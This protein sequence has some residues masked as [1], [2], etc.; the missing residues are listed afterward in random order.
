MASTGASTAATR[1]DY[2]GAPVPAA[3][4][5]RDNAMRTLD[6]SV[7]DG[8][9]QARGAETVERLIE[10][11]TPQSR[12]WTARWAAATGDPNYLRAVA[13]KLSPTPTAASCFVD[14]AESAAWRSAA[15]VQAER[16]MSTTD[17]SGGF[18]IPMQLDP[19]SCCR[20][21]VLQTRCGRWRAWCK[22]PATPGTASPAPASARTGTPKRPKS[23][24]IRRHWC[25]RPS[26][27]TAAAHGSHSASNLKVTAQDFVAEIGRLLADSVEQLTATAY[28]TGS[29]SGQPTGFITAL[30][31]SNP[32]VIVT[33]DGS[34]ALAAT[35]PY[36]LQNA[37]PARF[38]ANSAFAANLS[39]KILANSRQN[40]ALKFPSLQDN[41]PRLLGRRHVRGSEYG[42]RAKH[43]RHRSQLS[44]GA[45]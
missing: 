42:F 44:A 41:P 14:T 6:R 27:Y 26:R 16:A 34:E 4:Q 10:V 35:D 28:V 29:G 32:T 23:P 3:V 18:L 11:G 43:L 21:P 2:I 19:A 25:S 33:G 30:V 38:Q 8:T 12:S 20:Q 1:S 13:K 31:A 15:A 39:I 9:L 24:T 17:A 40:G 22:P 36:K 7:K 45:G 5:Q 37:L